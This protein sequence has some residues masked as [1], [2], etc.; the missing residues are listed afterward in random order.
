MGAAELQHLLA[1][2]REVLE[3]GVVLAILPFGIAWM[4]YRRLRP[5]RTRPDLF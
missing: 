2:A 5:T 1:G 3:W 4:G